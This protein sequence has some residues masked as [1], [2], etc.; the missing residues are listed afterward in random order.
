MFQFTRSLRVWRI[1]SVIAI[2]TALLF[3][4]QAAVA[5]ESPQGAGG[6]PALLERAGGGIVAV[7]KLSEVA[8]KQRSATTWATLVRTTIVIPTSDPASF[9]D[10][11]FSGESACSGGGSDP[12]WC[13]LRI[14][15]D[16]V[17]ANPI[18]GT[19]FAFD[20]TNRG[21]ETN[22]SWESHAIER[23][24]QCLQPGTHVVWVEWASVDFVAPPP[25]FSIDDWVLAIERVRGCQ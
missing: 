2:S 10:M 25:T 19:D 24:S 8:A 12:A 7:K 21:R 11:R 6:D 1:I 20:S 9:L 14:M 23:Y 22:A 18:V 3:A 5:D 16:G 13:T 15:V 4:V 17:E